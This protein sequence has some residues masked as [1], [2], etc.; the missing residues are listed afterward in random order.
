MDIT[1]LLLK[2]IRKRM[3]MGDR[4][5]TSYNTAHKGFTLFALT[6]LSEDKMATLNEVMEMLAEA[7]H[8][9]TAD[10]KTVNFKKASIP[11]EEA[12]YVFTLKKYAN[13]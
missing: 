12:E 3:W 7:T 4:T 5:S 10:L 13:L 11:Q 8:T 6:E 1:G 9:T 2:T